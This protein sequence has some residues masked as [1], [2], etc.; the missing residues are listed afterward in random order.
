MRVILA[1]DHRVVREGL[2]LLLADEPDIDIVGEAADGRELLDLLGEVQADVVLLDV[3]MPKM[4]GLEALSEVHGIAP[5]TKVIILSMHD[6][7]AYVKRAV[8][9]GAS[10][11]L[12][13]SAGQ[14]EVIR[15]LEAV[16]AGGSYIQGEV[17]G[18]LVEHVRTPE[19]GTSELSPREKEVL[20]LVAAG[21]E[22]KQIARQLEISEAT[23]KTYLKSIF[24][25]LGVRSRAEAVAVGL[26][27]GLIE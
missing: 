14:E 2:R 26:R 3:R 16:A 4:S 9:L 8:E 21:R 25:R 13:K 7:P 15:A 6:E 18:P 23:V 20:E 17:V 24:E 19:P 1:D 22:N 5:D 11:Y 27:E 10:G 12:V